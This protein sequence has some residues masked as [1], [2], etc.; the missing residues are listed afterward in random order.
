[1]L[2]IFTINRKKRK[3]IGIDKTKYIC[4][5]KHQLILFRNQTFD[6]KRKIYELRSS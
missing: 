1:M 6:N 4:I 2:G 3:T 5:F